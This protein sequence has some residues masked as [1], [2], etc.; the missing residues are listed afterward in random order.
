MY[1][2][3]SI[4]ICNICFVATVPTA[5]VCTP[6]LLL[7]PLSVLRDFSTKIHS[8]ELI[9]HRRNLKIDFQ[10]LNTWA[11]KDLRLGFESSSVLNTCLVD[12]RSVRQTKSTGRRNQITGR[13]DAMS[14]SF[15]SVFFTSRMGTKYFCPQSIQMDSGTT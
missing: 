4:T 1:S 3:S 11:N 12:C 10:F 15:H 7:P 2:G 9:L 14:C 8:M 13:A 5:T 6:K